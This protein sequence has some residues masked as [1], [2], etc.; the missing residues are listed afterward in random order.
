MKK[1]NNYYWDWE[2][3]FEITPIKIKRKRSLWDY[4]TKYKELNEKIN[5]Y[6]LYGGFKWRIER[7]LSLYY[8]IRTKLLQK[9]IVT[10]IF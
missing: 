1:D 4:I 5:Y 7:T 3:Q 6:K 2:K 10:N 9:S 8:A